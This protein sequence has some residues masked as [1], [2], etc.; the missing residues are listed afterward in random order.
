MQ[1]GLLS[2]NFPRICFFWR[3]MLLIDA[4]LLPCYDVINE[5]VLKIVS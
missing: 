5:A 2:S 1:K 3:E 4:F